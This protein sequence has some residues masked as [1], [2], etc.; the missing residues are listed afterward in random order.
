MQ[1]RTRAHTPQRQARL[2]FGHRFTCI[3]RLLRLLKP[4]V[5]ARDAGSESQLASPRLKSFKAGD[6]ADV[7][8]HGPR[9]FFFISLIPFFFYTSKQEMKANSSSNTCVCVI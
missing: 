2:I 1:T 7:L 6:S 5:D 3:R 9:E 4:S 8:T